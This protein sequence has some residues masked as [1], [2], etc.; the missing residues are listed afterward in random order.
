[1]ELNKALEYGDLFSIYGALLTQNQQKILSAYY[2]EDLG[3]SEISQNLGITRQAVLD[4]INKANESLQKFEKALQIYAKN[5]K[6]LKLIN[7]ANNLTNDEQ[8]VQILN[9]IKNNL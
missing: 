4:A 8:L 9:E 2:Y 6:T 5:A 3:L 7:K 1:M